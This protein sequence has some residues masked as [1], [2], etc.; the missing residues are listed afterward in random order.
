MNR[1]PTEQPAP[2]HATLCPE[3]AAAL[4]ALLG[5]GDSGSSQER[6]QRVAEV[7]ALLA[8]FDRAPAGQISSG[9]REALLARIA[10]YRSAADPVWL[11][12]E[13]ARV[14]DALLASH[15]QGAASS[16][17]L[18]P[19]P[20]GS[21]ERASVAA[22]VVAL[23]DRARPESPS[24]DLADRTMQHIAQQRQHQVLARLTHDDRPGDSFGWRIGLRQIGS[25]AAILVIGMSLLVPVLSQARNQAEQ[26]DCRANLARAGTGLTQYANDNQGRLPQAARPDDV[27]S[28][29]MRFA[30]DADGSSIPSSAVHMLVLPR[31]GYLRDEQLTCPS[32]Q[33]ELVM[34]G[35]YSTQHVEGTRALRLTSF[36]GPLMAD[37]NPLYT[38]QGGRAVRLPGLEAAASKNHRQRG[39]NVL[40]A[41]T[42]IQWTIAP[43][44]QHDD[45]DDNLW[46][47]D[48]QRSVSEK[49]GYDAFLT[50]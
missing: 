27:F 43:V 19:I 8:L 48:R 15:A 9:L 39:Q 6:A 36:D 29:L 13:D 21:F 45:Q 35:L 17:S 33:P 10:G 28:E 1:Q 14:V 2:G 22:S 12:E 26:A 40:M 49:D 16:A 37:T 3:D 42:S 46:A 24:A 18:G 34:G 25:V 7:L 31:E 47:A 41:D 32:G 38:L 5:E 23:L 11:C 4:D 30:E 44:V 20:A 50:P